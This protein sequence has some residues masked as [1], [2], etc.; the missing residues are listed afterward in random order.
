VS[1]GDTAIIERAYG[2]A[3]S[4][5]PNTTDTRFS[6]ASVSKQFTAYAVVALQRRRLIRIADAVEDYVPELK[7][8]AAGK[9]T[10]LELLNHTSGLPA[11]FSPFTIL[12]AQLD[13]GY[14]WTSEEVIKLVSAY[15]SLGPRGQF[16]Y[17]DIGYE[18]L[19]ALIER[20]TGKSWSEALREVAFERY[21]LARTDIYVPAQKAP[22]TAAGYVAFLNPFTARPLGSVRMP[23]WNYSLAY[24]ASGIYSTA[25]DLLR[26]GRTVNLQHRELYQD[27]GQGEA[28]EYVAGW[29]KR[30]SRGNVPY[31]F[32][33]ARCPV[34]VLRTIASRNPLSLSWSFPIQT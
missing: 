4:A 6:I 28:V 3:G 29:I 17:S 14:G 11:Y 27:I 7:G 34:S 22:E 30:R 21:G 15:E 31:Y 8:K 23:A 25:S 24:G 12:R 9:A 33:P 10:L 13:P 1:I 16:V 19:R 32:I 20:V 26:W 2:F 18:L 5:T